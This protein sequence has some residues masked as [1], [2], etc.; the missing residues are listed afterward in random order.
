VLHRREGGSAWSTTELTWH[1][2]MHGVASCFV[3]SKGRTLFNVAC[4][5]ILFDSCSK[6]PRAL[7]DSPSKPRAPSIRSIHP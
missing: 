4:I 3:H 7:F 2:C 5:Y 6:R 1:P